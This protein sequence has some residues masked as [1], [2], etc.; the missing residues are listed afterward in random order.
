LLAENFGF[1]DEDGLDQR[2]GQAAQTQYER[3]DQFG[4]KLRATA[5]FEFLKGLL[6]GAR[7]LVRAFGSDRVIG[8]GDGNDARAERDLV[9]GESLRIA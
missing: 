6:R 2:V 4:I 3:A 7:L 5:T 8:I 9:A 1:G